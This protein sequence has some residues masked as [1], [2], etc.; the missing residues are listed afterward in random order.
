[1]RTRGDRGS[2]GRWDPHAGSRHEVVGQAA[3]AQ[4]TVLRCVVARVDSGGG[5][6]WLELMVQAA[7][8]RVWPPCQ[9]SCGPWW[10][11]V[12]PGEVRCNC[13]SLFKEKIL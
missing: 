11:I 4:A 8:M 2:L 5:L 13:I 10:S 9:L 12:R 3:R 6:R 1:M 7:C